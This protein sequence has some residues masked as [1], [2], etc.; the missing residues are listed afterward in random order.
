MRCLYWAYV[1]VFRCFRSVHR[2]LWEEVSRPIQIRTSNWLLVEARMNDGTTIDVT[3]HIRN[4][5]RDDAFLTP[6]KIGTALRMENVESYN[7]LTTTLEYN[8]IEADGIV[9]GL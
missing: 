4:V 1:N 6:D 7:Y 2:V 5:F 8:K 3:D 9:N